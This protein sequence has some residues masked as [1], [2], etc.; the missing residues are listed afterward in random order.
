VPIVAIPLIVVALVFLVIWFAAYQLHITAFQGIAD[1]GG[2]V[3]GLL[4]KFFMKGVNWAVAQAENDVRN[5]IK[6]LV[7]LFSIPIHWLQS[8]F[9]S[10]W[11]G[12]YAAYN[13]IYKLG[14]IVVPR[15]ISQALSTALG[16]VHQAENLA[17]A[18]LSQLQN[19]ASAQLTAVYRYVNTEIALAEHYSLILVQQAEAYTAAGLAAET[20]YA[21]GLYTSAIGYTDAQVKAL[22]GWVSGEI[23]HVT[24]WTGTE[25][26]SLS[27][28]ISAV[29]VQQL[30]YIT[31]L[32][33]PLALDLAK[34]DIECASRLC[35]NLSG[36]GNL[37]HELAGAAGIGA[38]I[39]LAAAAAA[40]PVDTA[41]ALDAALGPLASGIAFGFASLIGV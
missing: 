30:A 24:T 13:A 22:E 37:V 39:A 19:W 36:L 10:L 7:S 21:Q 11:S 17:A 38:L 9:D 18:G 12:I 20:K 41:S 32:V 15:L 23:G 25:I 5:G 34:I 26:Q 35:S 8:H 1:Q 31:A 33:G 6:Y 40:D 4:L 3:G 28:Y 29:Q 27:S 14:A 2:T 16:W